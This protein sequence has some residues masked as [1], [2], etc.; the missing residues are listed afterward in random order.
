MN[1]G[2][3]IGEA[4]KKCFLGNPLPVRCKDFEY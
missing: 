2:G 1:F 3:P 4:W